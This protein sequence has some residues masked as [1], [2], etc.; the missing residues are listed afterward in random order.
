MDEGGTQIVAGRSGATLVHVAAI[1][2]GDLPPLEDMADQIR[3]QIAESR[4]H[5]TACRR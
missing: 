1:T 3:Q 5:S 4:G 2:A